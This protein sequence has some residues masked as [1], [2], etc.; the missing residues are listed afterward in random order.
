MKRIFF[1]LFVCLT[2]LLLTCGWFL[3]KGLQVDVLHAGPAVLNNVTLQWRSKLELHIETIDLNFTNTRRNQP[4]LDLG[5]AEKIVPL[6]QWIDRLFS[7]LSVKQLSFGEIRGSCLYESSQGQIN[8]SSPFLGGYATFKLAGDTLI[9]DI[10]NLKSEAF[11]S[12]ASGKLQFDLNEKSGIGRFELLLADSLPVNIDLSLDQKRLSFQGGESELITTITPFVDLFGLPSNIQRWITDYLIGSRYELKSFRGDFPWDNPLHLLESF[13]AEARVEGCQYAFATDLDPIKSEYTDVVFDKGVLVILPHNA[14]FYGQAT[15][16]SWLDIN[17]NL[18]SN[19]LLTAYIQTTAQANQDIVDLLGYYDILLPFKQT[20]GKTV[21]DLILTVN[22]YTD[23]VTARGTFSIDEGRVDYNQDNYGLKKTIIDLDDTVISFRQM[24]VSY[25]DMFVAD[26]TGEFDADTDIGDLDISLQEASFTVGKFFLKLAKGKTD[27]SFHY[28]IRPGDSVITGDSSFWELDA[29]SVRLAEFT[30][31]FSFKDFAGE[32]EPTIL[33][34]LPGITAEI[35]G[36]FSLQDKIFDLKADI[37]KYHSQ[38]LQLVDSPGTLM[39]KYDKNMLIRSESESKWILHGVP[40][41]LSPAE[42]TFSEESFAINRG[43]V[44]YGDVFKSNV[45][46]RYNHKLKKG[47]FELEHLDVTNEK[48][49]HVLAPS[50]ILTVQVAVENRGLVFNFPEL[51]A[52]F[53]GEDRNSWSFEA[54]DLGATAKYSP[55][56]QRLMIDAGSMKV[57]SRADGRAYEFWADIPYRYALLVKDGQ[58]VDRYTVLGQSSEHGLIATVNKD[59]HLLF[60]EKFMISARDTFLNLPGIFQFL[61]EYPDSIRDPEEKEELQCTIEVVEGGLVVAPDRVLLADKFRLDSLHGKVTASIEYGDGGISVDIEGNSF[62]LAGNR[63]NDTFMEALAPDVDFKHGNMAVVARGSF[64][65]YSVLLEIKDTV[66]RNFNILNNI[67]AIFNTI[68]ALITFNLPSYSYSGLPVDVLVVGMS[69]KDGFSTVNSMKLESPELSIAGVGWIDF[70]KRT[71]GMD[72]NLITQAKKNINK[73]PLLGFIL[74][75]KEKK[76]SINVQISGDLDDPHV[77]YST[78]KKVATLP[79]AMLF[80]TLLLPA[81][82]IAPI[83]GTTKD[84]RADGDIEGKREKK[85]A[86]NEL[87]GY[88]G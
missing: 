55:F 79:F 26:V 65:E 10:S 75:G 69:V 80:R 71:I 24:E 12:T 42:L 8:F 84:E 52:E 47:T 66:F 22:L 81:H 45:S 59:I 14:T 28:R 53:I 64:D 78:F 13:H 56:L 50:D 49:G 61:K 35:S 2:V 85:D 51:S 16:D 82:L 5:F 87:K 30:S 31:S 57:V 32:L 54:E 74:A 63:L 41:V 34:V 4:S 44:R 19:I 76:P 39:L 83:F 73:I 58:P 43:G 62:M 77:T 46:G 20:E 86:D 33:S 17:F 27:P 3:K 11:N 88:G 1:Y 7:K 23:Q 68:P 18:P 36:K 48:I 70:V 38:Y 29:L 67:L 60:K 25:G 37:L 40:F 6:F 9:V 21:T 15:E 72:L